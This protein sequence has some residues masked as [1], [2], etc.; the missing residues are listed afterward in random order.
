MLLLPQLS[1]F[2]EL[3]LGQ[4]E[5]KGVYTVLANYAAICFALC[6]VGGSS[7]PPGSKKF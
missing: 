5:R 6:L 2:C 4:G 1:L 7:L 3:T